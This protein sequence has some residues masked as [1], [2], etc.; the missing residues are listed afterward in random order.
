MEDALQK[1]GTSG[2]ERVP[3]INYYMNEVIE[4]L[5]SDIQKYFIGSSIFHQGLTASN[6]PKNIDLEIMKILDMD[7]VK[8]SQILQKYRERFITEASV[9]KS[10]TQEFYRIFKSI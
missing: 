5:I 3:I 8:R 2:S 10:L 6:P 9:F 4:L 7:I 1:F